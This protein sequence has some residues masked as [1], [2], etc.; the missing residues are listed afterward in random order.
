MQLPMQNGLCLPPFD[1][2]LG[3]DKAIPLIS[4][5]NKCTSIFPHTSRK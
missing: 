1:P 2:S 3:E 5:E 4:I